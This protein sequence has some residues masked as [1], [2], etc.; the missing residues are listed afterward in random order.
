MGLFSSGHKRPWRSR[1]TKIMIMGNYV[2][3]SPSQGLSGNVHLIELIFH[4][5]RLLQIA[6]GEGRGSALTLRCE[7]PP[8]THEAITLGAGLSREDA[9]P[10]FYL[11]HEAIPIADGQRFTTPGG[12]NIGRVFILPSAFVLYLDVPQP[13]RR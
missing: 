11:N 7:F 1:G 4:E 8:G 9:Q 13:A 12:L 2:A 6:E 5:D 3:S 10:T